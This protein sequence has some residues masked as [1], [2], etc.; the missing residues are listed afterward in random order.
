MVV[1]PTKDPPTDEALQ[2]AQRASLRQPTNAYYRNTLGAAQ[3]RVGQ[4]T[5]A[6]RNLNEVD[7]NAPPDFSWRTHNMFFQAICQLKLG[8]RTM[9]QVAY[10]K[11]LELLKPPEGDTGVWFEEARLLKNEVEELLRASAADQK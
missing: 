6:L 10:D 5:E 3:C 8:D 7:K 1:R 9:A 11:A 4:F 2:F